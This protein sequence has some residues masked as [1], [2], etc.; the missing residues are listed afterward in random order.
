MGILYFFFLAVYLL[1]TSQPITPANQTELHAALE[2]MRSS[3]YHGFVIL[4]QMLNSVPNSIRSGNIT[5]LMP[6][7]IELSNSVI[8]PDSL[9]EFLLSHSVPTAL[10]LDDFAHLPTGTVL[11]TSYPHKTINVRDFGRANFFVNN[12]KIVKPNVCSSSTIK[13]HGVT[14]IIMFNH[15]SLLPRRPPP[16]C[17]DLDCNP[18]ESSPHNVPNN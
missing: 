15:D 6:N 13:C 8:T 18:P 10:L 4:L 12:A 2:D 7:D 9:D 14:S 17:K 11:P 3:S 5:F 1:F 16:V